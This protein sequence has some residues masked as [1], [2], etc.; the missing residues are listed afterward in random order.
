[1]FGGWGS[2]SQPDI[3]C[4]QLYVQNQP[5][6]LGGRSEGEPELKELTPQTPGWGTK[7][8]GNN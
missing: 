4:E 7:E 2:V 1:M 6:P 8:A 3:G 5:G